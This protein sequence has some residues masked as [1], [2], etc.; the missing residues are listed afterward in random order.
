M[1]TLSVRART[2]LSMACMRGAKT[3]TDFVTICMSVAKRRE[4]Y[5]MDSTK[6]EATV[7]ALSGCT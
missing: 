4:V 5:H 7:E 3:V 1:A 6:I 2:W